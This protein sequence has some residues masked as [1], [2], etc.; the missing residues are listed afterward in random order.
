MHGWFLEGHLADGETI[1]RVPLN[2]FPALV[3]RQADLDVTLPSGNVSRQHARFVQRGGELLLQ[4]L[5]SRNGTFVNHDHIG[6]ECRLRPGDVLRF[7]DMEFR[8]RRE[9]GAPAEAPLPDIT[10]TSFFRPDAKVDRL[11]IGAR[12]F[13]QL[14][15]DRLITPLFQP[16]VSASENRLTG[17]ELLGRGA[18][19]GLSELPEPLFALAE[20]LGRAVN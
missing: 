12:Q 15:R 11:P 1:Y 6:T 3:G 4:D 17:L 13:E 10:R 8:L 5:G 7:A 20:G 19:P 9:T 2:R 16:I 18:H 14:L